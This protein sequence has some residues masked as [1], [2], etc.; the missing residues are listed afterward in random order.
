VI[1]VIILLSIGH[2]AIDPNCIDPNTYH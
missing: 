2:H 1:V